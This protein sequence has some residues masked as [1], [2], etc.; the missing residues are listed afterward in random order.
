MSPVEHLLT[1]KVS[2]ASLV[3][4]CAS[5]AI[6]ILLPII[7]FLIFRNKYNARAIPMVAG[8]VSFFVF[9]LL[10]EPLFLS[11]LPL[12]SVMGIYPTPAGNIAMYVIIGC[13]A[14]GVFE[15]TGRFIAIR[16]LLRK[17]NG[18]IDTP[19]S[20]GVGHGGIEAILLVGLPLISLIA[21]SFILNS[22]GMGGALASLS[23]GDAASQAVAMI[24]I[25]QE[26]PAMFLA[27]GIERVTA[28]A[29][30]ICA[31]TLVWLAA[32][33]RG[34]LWLYPAAILIHAAFNVPAA[35]VQ[36]GVVENV[37]VTEAILAVFTVCF[38]VVTY[39][40]LRRSKASLP[41]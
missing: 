34:K 36:T 8:M 3:C 29:F 15:E 23:E 26:N 13:L 11:L 12:D 40:R 1:L 35:L 14:S 4:M 41:E 19:L 18:G 31:S 30:H 37:W 10:L 21:S 9:A 28:I 20:Y 32:T 39:S 17:N 7:L 5:A 24:D 38:A 16:W 33:K 2:A 27:G 22:G 6:A 25:V